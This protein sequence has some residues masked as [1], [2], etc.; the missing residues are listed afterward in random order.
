MKVKKVTDINRGTRGYEVFSKKYPKSAQYY[1]SYEKSGV[2]NIYKGNAVENTHVDTARTFGE[3]KQKAFGLLSGDQAP[4][5]DNFS[6][7]RENSQMFIREVSAKYISL[8]TPCIQLSS[9]KDVVAFIKFQI[10]N[11]PAENFV[12]LG[13]NNKNEVV[14]FNK[15]FK[16]TASECMVH[17]REIFL[18]AIMANCSA[19]IVAHNH[20]SGHTTPSRPDIDSTKRL[21][22]SGKLLGIPVLDHM[23]VG[24]GSAS[25][26]SFKENGLI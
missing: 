10:Q 14:M 9:P 3:A 4:S 6:K 20:P 2:W 26:Y 19:I 15:T 18:S 13:V 16:G 1:V 23:I 12:V 11:D 22:E 5:D 24:F 21:V 25:Y 8:D 17:P 7:V